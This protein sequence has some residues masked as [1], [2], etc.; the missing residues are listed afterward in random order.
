M[1][2]VVV[3]HSRKAITPKIEV[4]TSCIPVEI[5][6]VVETPSFSTVFNWFTCPKAQNKP[7]IKP[8]IKIVIV[9]AG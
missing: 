4:A 2:V 1:I 5:V 9:K 8:T 7:E 3:V 6:T